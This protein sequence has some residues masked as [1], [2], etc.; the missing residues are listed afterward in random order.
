[1]TTEL[2]SVRYL[3][4][5]V[6]AALAFYTSNLGFTVLTDFSPAFADV[7][8]GQLRLLLSGPASSAGG[9]VPHGGQA[10]PGGWERVHPV[11]EHNGGGGGRVSPPGGG[12]PHDVARG[13]GG[14]E[15]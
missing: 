7:V 11:V 14:K 1:M 8:R 5:D 4:D 10:G 6:E 2:V 9:G 15:V 12:F 13:A 3:V